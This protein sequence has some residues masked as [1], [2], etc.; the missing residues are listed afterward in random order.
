[1]QL[2]PSPIEQV[3]AITNLPLALVA[4][5]A[6]TCLHPRRHTQPLRAWLWIGVFGGLALATGVGI[7]AHGLGLDAATR[8]LLWHPINA[9]LALTVACFVAGAVL[10]RWGPSAARWALPALLL[11]S[12][13]FFGYAT[14]WASSFLPFIVYEGVAMLFC[15]AVFL[16]LAVQRRLPGAGWMVAGVA[17]T[18]LAAVLQAMPRVEFQLG[19]TFDHNGVFHLVQ[20][21][22]LLCLLK[23]VLVGLGPRPA[24]EPVANG[25]LPSAA[26]ST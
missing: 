11:L 14:F 8:R 9:A 23:G 21:P 1:M 17:I 5:A 24:R 22:G 19:V 4:L 10:D 13:G 12:A 3:T 6:V 20:L 7:F 2:N 18:I 25:L 26:K 16:S 15:L